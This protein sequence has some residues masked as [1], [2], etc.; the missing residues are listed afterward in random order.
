MQAYTGAYMHVYNIYLIFYAQSLT[1]TTGK[2]LL[3]VLNTLLPLPAEIETHGY[4]NR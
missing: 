2:L 1:C 4:I 3:L